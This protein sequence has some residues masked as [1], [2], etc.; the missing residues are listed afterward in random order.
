VAVARAVVMPVNE[1]LEPERRLP[2]VVGPSLEAI[3]VNGMW[4]ERFSAADAEALRASLDSRPAVRAALTSYERARGQRAH[5]RR[6]RRATDAKVVT[7]PY[8]F[9]AEIGLPEYE[10]L[11]AALSRKL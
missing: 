4:P 11:A 8:L 3:V 9:D 10:K 2:A 1:T 6:L 5:L 7:L